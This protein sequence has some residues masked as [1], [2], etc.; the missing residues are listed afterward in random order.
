MDVPADADADAAADAGST[1][2]VERQERGRCGKLCL[3]GIM[4]SAIRETTQATLTSLLKLGLSTSMPSVI[5]LPF[6]LFP[7]HFTTH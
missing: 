6:P 2:L 3:V 7:F 5:G 1:A 4:I